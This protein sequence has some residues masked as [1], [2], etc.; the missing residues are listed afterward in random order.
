MRPL[1]HQPVRLCERP[2]P[3]GDVAIRRAD[4]A[5][6]HLHGESPYCGSNAL[7]LLL[8]MRATLRRMEAEVGRAAVLVVVRLGVSAQLPARLWQMSNP[9]RGR[10]TR[11]LADAVLRQ[12]ARCVT[13]MKPRIERQMVS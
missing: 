9:G 5:N 7:L 11:L 3:S 4:A 6:G 12:T 2:D 8:S 13:E 10:D 1:H